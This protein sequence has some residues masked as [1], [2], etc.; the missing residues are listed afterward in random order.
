M[1]NRMPLLGALL[2]TILGGIIGFFERRDE[3]IKI[4]H[5]SDVRIRE[6]ETQAKI[7]TLESA[8]NAEI[9][10]DTAAVQQME[11]TWKDEWFVFLFSVPLILAFCGRWG[12]EIAYNGFTALEGMPEWYIIS[13]GLIVASTFGYRKLIDIMRE[14]NK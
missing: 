11:R 6:A 7:K 10:W 9:A 2:T 8:Q 14:R 13:L 5:E 12:R 3:R 1:Y 4:D